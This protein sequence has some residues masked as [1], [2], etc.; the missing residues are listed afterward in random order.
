MIPR[1]IG[2]FAQQNTQWF[3]VVYVTGPRQSGKSTLVQELFAD[4]EY[5][6]L[7]LPGTLAAALDDPGGF[8]ANRTN[9]LII[10]EAQRAPELFNVIQVASDASGKPGQYI[11][12]GSQNF[13]MRKQIT[14]SLAGRAG[15]VRLL[16]F[17]YQELAG[18]EQSPKISLQEFVIRGGYP[19][20]YDVEIPASVYYR[21]YVETYIERDVAELI[22]VSNLGTFKTFLGLC[23]QACGN[24]LNISRLAADVGVSTKTVRSWLSVLETSYIVF[25]LQPYHA[26]IRKRLTKTPKLYFYDTGLLCHLLG[27]ATESELLNSASRGAIYENMVV[28]ETIKRHNNAGK[29][30]RLAFYRDDEKTEVDLVDATDAHKVELVE[31]KASHTYRP[32]FTKPL[33]RVGELLG[34]PAGQQH[35]VMFEDK[36]QAIQSRT[37]WRMQDW[38]LRESSESLG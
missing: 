21:N 10:D 27:I 14:Q 35:L 11:L 9:K 29:E 20:L 25:L 26:N 34:I 18:A 37:I 8:I 3:P 22:N 5:E 38:L 2:T 32:Q 36:T 7:E 23:A 1:S 12:S 28:T 17:S 13:L 19:R 15:I 4:Y 16:P 6:N 31:I 30:P 24:L 33:A